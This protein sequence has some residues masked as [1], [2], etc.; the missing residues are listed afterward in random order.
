MGSYHPT[1]PSNCRP[2]S[3]PGRYAS[4]TP[5]WKLSLITLL[6]LV[7]AVLL[8]FLVGMQVELLVGSYHPTQPS[9]CCPLSFLG[10]Y[11]SGTPGWKL[12]PYS[13]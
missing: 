12:S 2:L 7:T 1:E 8:A 9:N 11:A 6:N 10:R 3:F 4:G 13:T 5:G